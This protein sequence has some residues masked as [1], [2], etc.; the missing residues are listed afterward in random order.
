MNASTRSARK[1]PACR[2]V[3]DRQESGSLPLPATG[4]A[5]WT[6]DLPDAAAIKHDRHSGA[7]YSANPE[8]IYGPMDS[9]FSPAGCPGMTVGGGG[10]TRKTARRANHQKSGQPFCR[11]YS[12]SRRGQITALTPRVS[13]RMRGGSRSSRTL[14]W[15]AVDAAAARD[16]RCCCGRRSRVVLTPRRWR[17]IR[18]DALP[19]LAGD[20]D[21]KARSPGRARRK[22]LKPLRREGRAVPV[23]LW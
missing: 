20:G 13:P 5:G 23:Y 10:G 3:A 11:K 14:R 6:D 18:E 1:S 16:E 22:P 17:Q 2:S 7:R 21:N 12:A 15:N 19:R 9:W 8:S 4:E